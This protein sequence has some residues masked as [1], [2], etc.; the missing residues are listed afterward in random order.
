MLARV[1]LHFVCVG[2]GAASCCPACDGVVEGGETRGLHVSFHF[3]QV[4][5]L[6]VAW[7]RLVLPCFSTWRSQAYYW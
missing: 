2:S 7:P 4:L 6:Q 1:A 3:L 5:E